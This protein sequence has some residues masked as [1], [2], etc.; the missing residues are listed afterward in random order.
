M[1]EP[2]RSRGYPAHF[3]GEVI[4]FVSL[5]E[6][7]ARG[8]YQGLHVTLGELAPWIDEAGARDLRSR[9]AFLVVQDTRPTPLA[10]LADIVL[11]G[12]T[13]AE[14]AGC[15]VNADE[16]LQYAEAVLSPRDGSLPDLDLFAI[17]L[18]RGG[19]PIRSRAILAELA[20][21]VHAF[22]MVRGGPTSEFGVPYRGLM[23]VR[24][25]IVSSTPGW[26]SAKPGP[27]ARSKRNEM[28]DSTSH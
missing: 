10:H 26:V 25:H 5:L 28:Y 12:A 21:A 22:A 8:A 3:Q 24:Q 1:P 7:T 14:K 23:W 9:V 20:E 4:D 11:A 13:F 15:Y 19:G 6:R 17:L 27:D 18:G 16:R 2:P